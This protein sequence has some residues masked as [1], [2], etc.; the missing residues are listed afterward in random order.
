MVAVLLAADEEDTTS[1]A[2]L[3][4]P[5]LLCHLPTG[6]NNHA[7][8]VE[9]CVFISTTTHTNFNGSLP[10]IALP[11]YHTQER[12][13]ENGFFVFFLFTLSSTCCWWQ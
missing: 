12:W 9:N 11:A 6:A 10:M 13:K 8:E 3:S 7:D 4:S 5:F 1:G 2:S